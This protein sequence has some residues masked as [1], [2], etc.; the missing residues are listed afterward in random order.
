MKTFWESWWRGLISPEV[1]GSW[2]GTRKQW[3]ETE[4]MSVGSAFLVT[5]VLCGLCFYVVRELIWR[6][7]NGHLV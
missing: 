4:G 7:S 1:P 2:K 3:I 5:F 6:K